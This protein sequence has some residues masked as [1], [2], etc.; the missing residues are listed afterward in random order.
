MLILSKHA[1]KSLQVKKLCN[2][3]DL[4]ET[5][6]NTCII[7]HYAFVTSFTFSMSEFFM[8]DIEMLP[9][10]FCSC[11]ILKKP[12]DS[13]WLEDIRPVIQRGP[14]RGPTPT[15]LH[16]RVL[17]VYWFHYLPCHHHH[18]GNL[19]T[20]LIVIISIIIAIIIIATTTTNTIIVIIIAIITQG[21]CQYIDSIICL[22]P[23]PI[24]K[25]RLTPVECRVL[26]SLIYKH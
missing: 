4:I 17:P 24:N 12:V 3:Q 8:S 5:W 11:D 15:Q 25:L 21:S 18:H 14:G 1:K 20:P 22:A 26:P 10:I 16:P 13:K 9:W 7:L 6:L 23:Q 19:L 2:F